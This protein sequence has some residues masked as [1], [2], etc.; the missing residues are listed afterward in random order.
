MVVAMSADRDATE[1]ARLLEYIAGSKRTQ[2]L[3]AIGLAAATAGVVVTL[4]LA[5]MVGKLALLGVAI[6]GVCGFWVTAAHIS[7]WRM[8]IARLDSRARGRAA[9]PKAGAS[10]P[11]AQ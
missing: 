4:L 6:V 1:R 3:L 11:P 9:D 2:R 7:D 5:P 10:R 8:Q